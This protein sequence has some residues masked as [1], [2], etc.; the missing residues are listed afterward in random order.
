M[1]RLD[2]K[3]EMTH[4]CICAFSQLNTIVSLGHEDRAGEKGAT[5][6]SCW[7]ELGCR[8]L[9]MSFVDSLSLILGLVTGGA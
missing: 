8:R 5:F 6:S 7:N 9:S 2:R 3:E 1:V 4:C